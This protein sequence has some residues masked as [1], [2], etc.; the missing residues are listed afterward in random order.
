M[1]MESWRAHPGYRL[2]VCRFPARSRPDG[3]RP[4]RAHRPRE[5]RTPPTTF[6][7]VLHL[8]SCISTSRTPFCVVPR[9]G[10]WPARQTGSVAIYRP[11]RR[12]GGRRYREGRLADCGTPRGAARVAPRRRRWSQGSASIPGTPI[13]RPT[14]NPQGQSELRAWRDMILPRMNPGASSAPSTPPWVPAWLAFSSPGRAVPPPYLPRSPGSD[15]ALASDQAARC[16]GGRAS[17][18]RR[19]SSSSLS[20]TSSRQAWMSMDDDVSRRAARRWVHRLPLPARC[21]RWPCR[22]CRR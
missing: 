22:G 13:P 9:R 11:Q 20:S 10:P 17:L 6:P 4:M 12:A 3:P 7:S 16:S 8:P 19:L 18:R 14:W 2:I 15:S 1:R 5:R 21:G